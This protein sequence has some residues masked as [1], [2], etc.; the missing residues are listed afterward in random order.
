[1]K[2]SRNESKDI[3]HE[4]MSYSQATIGDDHASKEMSHYEID[5]EHNGEFF[6]FPSTTADSLIHV[7]PHTQTGT[8]H[9][10]N[11]AEQVNFTYTVQLACV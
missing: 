8:N 10:S 9:C 3:S 11:A 2:P 4:T 6:G 1:M 7:S 5:S